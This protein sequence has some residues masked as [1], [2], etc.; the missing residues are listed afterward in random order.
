[1]RTVVLVER[2]TARPGH[3]Q[4]A[5]TS[6]ADAARASGDYT[7][8]IALERLPAPLHRQLENDEITV[9]SSPRG[10]RGHLLH[11]LA[12]ATRHLAAATARTL[13]HRRLPHQLTLLSRALIEAASLATGARLSGQ[14]PPDIAVVLTA[15]EGLHGL[16]RAL[17]GI[18]HLRVVHEVTTTEDAPL[19][20]LGRLSRPLWVKALCPTE[21][22]RQDL[23]SRFPN[24]TTAV[25][26]FALAVKTERLHPRER[27]AARRELGI[28]RDASVLSLVGGWWPHKDMATLTAALE[29]ITRPLYVL[30]AGAPADAQLLG[31]M[32]QALNTTLHIHQGTPAPHDIRRIYAA[33]DLTAVI[34]HP[35]V[36]KES[37]LVADCAR[38]GVPLLLTDHDPDLT[39]RTRDWATHVPPRD[40][41]SLADALD[42]ATAHPPPTPPPHAVQDLGLLTP[43]QAL[44]RLREL[45]P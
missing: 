38:L 2:A 40:P 27:P 44:T 19:R 20:L 32:D 22:V 12:T 45:M 13:V 4:H 39:H 5:L 41:Q 33:A 30:I 29:L 1:M 8:V 25:Q 9:V 17:S 21:A 42:H 6:L 35:G 7:T 15:A 43:D 10:L 24:L 31:R 16:I 34:R 11:T 23:S 18:P 14:R 37:G 26:P 36:S 28:S 3:W